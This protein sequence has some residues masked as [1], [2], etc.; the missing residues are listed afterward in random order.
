MER[1]SVTEEDIATRICRVERTVFNKKR[2]P[3]TLTLLEIRVL[4]KLLKLN[5]QQ[6]V[7]LIG[8]KG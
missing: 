8:V 2:H 3:E 1:E 4:V 7:E 6:I 5:D